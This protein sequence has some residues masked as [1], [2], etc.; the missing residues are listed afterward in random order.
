MVRSSPDGS[1]VNS[2]RYVPAPLDP[3]DA[4]LGADH[5]M[6]DGPGIL[7]SLWRH[8]RVALVMM[9]LAALAGFFILWKLP[10]RYQAQATLVLRDPFTAGIL[11]DASGQPGDLAV[12]MAKQGDIMNSRAVLD[13]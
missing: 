2:N 5:G 6:R 7:A 8:R 13:R 3:A 9:L 4:G 12:Y 1:P 10:A 11:G